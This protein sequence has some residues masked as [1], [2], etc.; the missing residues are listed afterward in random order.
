[1]LFIIESRRDNDFYNLYLKK[2]SSMGIGDSYSTTENYDL[3]NAPKWAKVTLGVIGVVGA[4]ATLY[5]AYND[6]MKENR[7]FSINR[8]LNISCNIIVLQSIL[9]QSIQINQTIT[10]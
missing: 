3:A 1:M 4:G 6:V 2:D 8:K 7:N 9:L 5:S 10:V